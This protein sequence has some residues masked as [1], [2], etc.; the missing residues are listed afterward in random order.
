MHSTRG[1]L[2]R[3]GAMVVRRALPT[4]ES[5][6]SVRFRLLLGGAA[7]ALAMLV[8]APA[9]SAHPLGNFT[10][11]RYARVEVSAGV[12]RIY[13]VLDEAEIPAFQEREAIEADPSGFASARAG[14]IVAG[15]TLTVDGERAPLAIEHL[16]LSR[17]PGQADLP[18]LRLAVLFAAPLPQASS[19]RVGTA[20]FA[21]GNEPGRV[22]WR[23]IVVTARGDARI[24]S[25]TAP[26]R[27]VSDELRSYPADL[28]QAPLDLRRAEFTF[29]QGTSPVAALP[30]ARATTAP[31]RAGGR[32]TSLIARQD[33]TPMVVAG[34]LA[35]GLLFGAGHA[36]AP[37]HGKTVMAFYLLGS[38][39]RVRDAAL[40]GVIVSLMHTVSVLGLGIVLFSVK[41]SFT[42]ER[43]YPVLT[44]ASGVGVLGVGVWLLRARVRALRVG[45]GHSDR[46]SE[47]GRLEPRNAGSSNPAA[48]RPG[49]G[50]APPAHAHGD[51]HASLAA[52]AHRHAHELP[53]GVSPLSRRGLFILASSGGIVPSPS[54][55][56]VMVGAFVLGRP[57]LA[58]ALIVSFSIGLAL[59]LATV[60][61]AVV[62]G[63][64]LAERH[65]A[66]RAMRLLPIAGAGAL[67]VLGTL[68]AAQGLRTIR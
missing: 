59:T 18:T 21:D 24:L 38:R 29:R 39:G 20:A 58:L 64:P 53:A 46:E 32:F 35:A 67:V 62:L 40:I 52:H 50:P 8:S 36:L 31:P 47:G 1:P 7:V 14:E 6:R 15:L 51:G 60:G 55:V 12:L 10:V 68:V 41:R 56:V 3:P 2:H 37:G 30:I 43:L 9:A 27:D 4:R 22:G 66:R 25:S 54:A 23:E 13:Y 19:D 44:L 49:A 26:A 57:A 65:V 34:M 33:L 16:R 11:N 48:D 42:P 63:R 45:N 5:R 17:P 61:T 28:L